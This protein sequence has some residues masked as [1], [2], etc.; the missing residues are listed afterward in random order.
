M[1]VI[2]LFCDGSDGFAGRIWS[3]GD[4]LEAMEMSIGGTPWIYLV[5]M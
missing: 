4:I 5:T 3:D 2:G 1:V